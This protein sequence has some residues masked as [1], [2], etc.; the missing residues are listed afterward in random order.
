MP[1]FAKKTLTISVGTS[2]T[3]VS[4]ATDWIPL[5]QYAAP[6]NVGFGI[7]KTGGG[8][9]T[10]RAEHTFD[11]VFD[12]DVTPVAFVHEE[13]S[14]ASV[15]IDGNLAFPVAAIRMAVVSAS[16]SSQMTLT[17]RQAGL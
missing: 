13:V 11:D 8:D 3:A 12:P 6:F 10:F 16:G 4:T 9:A 2:A 7:V 14:A 17:V 5:N 15:D 1:I